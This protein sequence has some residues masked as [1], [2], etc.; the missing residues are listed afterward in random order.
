MCLGFEWYRFISLNLKSTPF[1][2]HPIG[3]PLVFVLHLS[4][5]KPDQV[6]SYTQKMKMEP[7]QKIPSAKNERLEVLFFFFWLCGGCTVSHLL[8]AT[9]ESAWILFLGR[10]PDSSVV[11]MRH[12]RAGDETRRCVHFKDVSR[13]IP[14][15]HFDSQCTFQIRVCFDGGGGRELRS[16]G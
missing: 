3:Q 8:R 12:W 11:N 4:W 2:R 10:R 1:F 14:I 16:Q 9:G 6:T 13:R 15:L 5:E 7:W